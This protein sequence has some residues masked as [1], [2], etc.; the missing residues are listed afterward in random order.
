MYHSETQG[1]S[2]WHQTNRR[3]S[4][5]HS[6]RSPFAFCLSPSL[7]GRRPCSVAL[8]PESRERN[9]P[10][11]HWC[12]WDTWFRLRGPRRT[13]RT[14]PPQTAVGG[15]QSARACPRVRS[16]ST[17]WRQIHWWRSGAR[18]RQSAGT[19][20]CCGRT[21]P[22]ETGWL[23]LSLSGK[24]PRRWRICR[25][26][27]EGCWTGPAR[28]RAIPG[29]SAWTLLAAQPSYRTHVS[30]FFSTFSIF[31]FLDHIIVRFVTRVTMHVCAKCLCI[32]TLTDMTS[33]YLWRHN[34]LRNIKL[35]GKQYPCSSLNGLYNTIIP[36]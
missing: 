24:Y 10:R 11:W 20:A 1:W 28:P 21:R 25:G 3:N 16:H 15:S 31:A 7:S 34:V 29:P 18:P 35:K 8:P 33:W 32:H 2:N 27:P 22:A 13:A 26:W 14:G 23:P 4:G 30:G 6:T 19:T 36:L 17:F 5:F 12:D 9:S